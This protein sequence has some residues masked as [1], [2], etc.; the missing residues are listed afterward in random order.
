MW[1]TKEEIEDIY[2]KLLYCTEECTSGD[3][4]KCS[5]RVPFDVLFPVV[6]DYGMLIGALNALSGA[7]EIYNKE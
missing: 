4:W 1:M 5:K 2:C 6:K 3:C 7:L